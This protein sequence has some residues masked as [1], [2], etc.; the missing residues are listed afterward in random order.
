[1]KALIWNSPWIAQGDLLFY[2]N[3][4]TKHL[5]L[6][7]NLLIEVGYEVDVLLHDLIMDSAGVLSSKANCINLTI[8]ELVEMNGL[9]SDPS[10]ELYTRKN[11]AL[12][13]KL[14]TLLEQRLANNYD[15]VLLWET[16]VPFLEELFPDALIVHQMPGAFSR[17][18]YPHMITFDPTG[19]Y[20]QGSLHKYS[21][22]I[23]ISDRENSDLLG[24]FKSLS[25][26]YLSS[27]APFT[28]EDIDPLGK[29]EKYQLLPLQTSGHYAYQ[30]D[31]PYKSQA[32]YLVD[33]LQN[34]SKETGVIVTQYI[35]PKVKDTVLNSD[36][37]Q[38]IKNQWPNLIYSDSFDKFSS[39]SQYLLP[40][41]EDVVSCSSSI[42][43]QAMLWNKNIVI[44][45]DTY[46][47]NISSKNIESL[48]FDIPSAHN[49]VLNFLLNKNQPLA[50]KILKDKKFLSSLLEEMISRK[51]RRMS[52]LE[53][54]VDFNEI[55]E[56]YNSSVIDGFT[57]GRAA[58]DLSVA[59]SEI[60]LNNDDSL[61]LERIITRD[62]FEHITFDVFDTLLNR[63]TENPVDLFKFI[64][65][66]VLQLTN[67]AA[68]D[69]AKIRRASEIEART[70][71]ETEEV[72]LDDIYD[73]INEH[74]HF[75]SDLIDALK[76]CEIEF[77]MRF[78]KPRPAG[79]KL[80]DAA[81]KLNKPVSIVSDMY[82]PHCVVEEM[83]QVSGFSG[84]KKL[85]V[86]SSYG[87][88]KK[89]G[90]LFDIL[91]DDLKAKP[92]QILHI[93]D[94][95]IA[96]SKMAK[97]KGISSFR[98]IRSIERLRQ[99]E[100]YKNIFDPRKGM[101]EKNRSIMAGLI[102]A[103]LFDFPLKEHEENSLFMNDSFNLGFAGIGPLLTS[104]MQWLSKLAKKDG[105]DKLFFLSREGWIL[106]E[107]YDEINVGAE[108]VPSA[109]LHC[110]RRAVR[111]SSVQCK[112]DVIALAT[113]AYSP[114]VTLAQLFEARFGINLKELGIDR[115][116]F[117]LVLDKS[118]ASKQTFV[119][120]AQEFC[121]EILEQARTEREGYLSYLSAMGVKQCIKP[122]IVDI[123]WKGN[124]QGALGKLLE[125]SFNGYYYATLEGAEVWLER[126]HDLKGFVGDFLSSSHPSVVVNN[127]KLI[128]YLTCH[129]DKS[130]VS[131]TL[132]EDGN[133]V[134]K[135]REEP[136]VANRRALIEKVHNGAISYARDFRKR[137]EPVVHSLH[138]DWCA[139]EKV[140]ASFVNKPCKA[141][142]ALLVG[143]SFEDAFG[144]DS[145]IYVISKNIQGNSAWK[146]GHEI[147]FSK[148]V[149]ANAKKV[150]AK[151][152]PA[153]KRPSK[154]Q[155]L[156][157][158][159]VLSD[160][161]KSNKLVLRVEG[162]FIRLFSNKKK[163]DKYL[164]N[165][166]EFFIDS[167]VSVMKYWYGMTTK[168]E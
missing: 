103:R 138:G 55:D 94:N 41:V 79:K 150:E 132:D 143:Q 157:P 141:D 140:F 17:A 46:L 39:I 105:V 11:P 127:R 24:E 38:A 156:Q 51:K 160:V 137:Y 93:G 153:E 154:P 122:G 83:L 13:Q 50:S 165:R 74:Y 89:D 119:N 113:Q 12:E 121:G 26:N 126:G 68:E 75:S 16:P 116:E 88:S 151:N 162:R 134:R 92:Q 76:E 131:I 43:L 164:R 111:L 117:S 81:K 125:K 77:E 25:K 112:S 22:D 129:V 102:S 30:A 80:W 168:H 163:Y 104:Y 53:L 90:G 56:N 49:N 66:K 34:A 32:D 61:K 62:G 48:G 7:A 58:K 4:F 70:R 147:Y 161:R 152:T 18:P 114:G 63:P 155:P 20:K 96:D 100:I 159:L 118:N 85:Y 47:K 6:Q 139:S 69:F 84:Y 158:K 109:Y 8:A 97:E 9:L 64:E 5:A 146:A 59:A 106:K 71:S 37:F 57:F 45:Q 2:K 36:V 82:L 15:V 95:M 19:L 87:V 40:L 67:G 44:P 23:M 148:P 78:V 98:I 27:L 128:E 54:F 91:I 107:I 115:D 1:M 10:Q 108:C 123:G 60:K 149:S 145:Q 33:V 73:V 86:S 136:D 142:A 144:G 42:A 166:D 101:G 120:I 72:S 31:T 99:N 110:S 167:K 135:Y 130:L 133:L 52:G 14:K 28:L 3:C 35:T 21:S 124:M 65:I 29:F